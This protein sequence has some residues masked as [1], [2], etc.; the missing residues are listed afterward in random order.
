VIITVLPSGNIQPKMHVVVSDDGERLYP[1][2]NKHWWWRLCDEG[3]TWIRG[4]HEADSKEVAALR[5][6]YALG[7]T[8]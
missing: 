7:S 8:T 2:G 5:V 6:A 1:V 3:V 4:H